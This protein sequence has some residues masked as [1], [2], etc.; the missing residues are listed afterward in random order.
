MLRFITAV[1]ETTGSCQKR[2]LTCFS[3][4]KIRIFVLFSV[5]MSVIVLN[6]TEVTH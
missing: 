4:P 6:N 5:R 1:A 3:F 2:R